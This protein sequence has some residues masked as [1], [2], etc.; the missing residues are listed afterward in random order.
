M[1]TYMISCHHSCCACSMHFQ[2]FIDCTALMIIAVEYTCIHKLILW[3]YA[4]IV[5][6]S[7]VNVPCYFIISHRFL[8]S[9][10]KIRAAQ[11]IR[12]EVVFDLWTR[13]SWKCRRLIIWTSIVCVVRAHNNHAA[14][15]Q[16]TVW[17][18]CVCVWRVISTII[19]QTA[20]WIY[21]SCKEDLHS[22][23]N[24]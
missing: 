13:T 21:I 2:L 16:A 14:W 22:S 12:I 15:P 19:F 5:Y 4:C 17:C 8:N 18:V 3:W 20:T 1:Y 6:I 7:S 24:K 23:C 11:C 9:M 10:H